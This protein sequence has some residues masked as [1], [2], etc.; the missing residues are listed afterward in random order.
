MLLNRDDSSQ[1]SSPVE[2]AMGS[3]SGADDI[4]EV[5]KAHERFLAGE[6]EGERADL[7]NARYAGA[8]LNGVNLSQAQMIGADFKRA[9]FS[10][11]DLSQAVLAGGDYELADFSAANLTGADCR[12]ANFESAKLASADLTDADLRPARVTTN[13]QKQNAPTSL[14]S[15]DLE[16]AKFIRTNLSKARLCYAKAAGA[17]FDEAVMSKV[18]L[19]GADL[20]RSAFQ[21]SDLTGADLRGVS[22]ERAVLV[23][24]DLTGADMRSVH[25]DGADLSGVVLNDC[26]VVN[27]MEKLP[28]EIS[29]A[30]VGHFL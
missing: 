13:F 25:L 24:T 15:A 23:D 27:G 28:P 20:S 14:E 11:S 21:A 16:D 5:V 9:H 22:F 30:I 8:I 6:P 12:G 26:I 17:R 10:G 1:D 7:R 18:D 3:D 2:G 19:R 29:K 4:F